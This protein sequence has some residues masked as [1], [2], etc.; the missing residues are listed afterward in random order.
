MLTDSHLFLLQRCWEPQVKWKSEAGRSAPLGQTCCAGGSRNSGG[1]G[2]GRVCGRGGAGDI[3]GLR[4]WWGCPC[5]LTLWPR[6]VTTYTRT[7]TH[8]FHRFLEVET[9]KQAKKGAKNVYWS[10]SESCTANQRYPNTAASESGRGLEMRCG[11]QHY[12]M[13]HGFLD[14]PWFQNR[15]LFVSV[16]AE[17]LT[18]LDIGV[19]WLW[20]RE[21]RKLIG[22]N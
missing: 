1:G 9:G 8:E 21:Y 6:S 17:T 15:F 18:V 3:L 13:W 16:W 22:A 10:H 12:R 11:D 14:L 5:K 20:S 2:W 19:R 7:H 4:R